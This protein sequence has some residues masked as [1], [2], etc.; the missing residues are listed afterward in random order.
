[1]VTD[2]PEESVESSKEVILTS[3]SLR[4][5]PEEEAVDQVEE[6]CSDDEDIGAAEEDEVSDLELDE[7]EVALDEDKLDDMAVVD[8][9]IGGLAEK[10]P[11]S[12]FGTGMSRSLIAS[13]MSQGS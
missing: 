5:E 1:M 2:R 3:G 10:Y 9:E 12:G 4:E 7:P 6:P 13:R 11:S 8:A